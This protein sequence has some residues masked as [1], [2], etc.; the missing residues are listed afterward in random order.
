MVASLSAAPGLNARRTDGLRHTPRASQLART[1]RDARTANKALGSAPAV[2]MVAVITVNSAHRP[3]GR[4]ASPQASS[5]GRC[6][7]E[8]DV[9]AD[10]GVGPGVRHG[11][12]YHG[13]R[14]LQ[15]RAGRDE[16]SCRRPVCHLA[17]PV[18][19]LW[20][21]PWRKSVLNNARRVGRHNNGTYT[22]QS[23]GGTFST[24]RVTGNGEYTDKQ[25]FT[26]TTSGSSCL[27]EA[28]SRS[29]VRDV[30]P[31]AAHSRC[32]ADACARPRHAGHFGPRR[33]HQLL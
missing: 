15:Q 17:R 31:S 32:A 9:P 24:S 12:H 28:C 10:R 27:I 21:E 4:A 33:W 3:Y 30:Q 1:P 25:I 2:K 23:Y 7:L 22:V 6:A 29:Q 19:T 16:G 18:S 8:H 11:D 26:L 14:V 13:C 5:H 20:L